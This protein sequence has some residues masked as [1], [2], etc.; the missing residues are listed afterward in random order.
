MATVVST[1]TVNAAFFREIKEEDAHVRHLRDAVREACAHPVP[2]R[3]FCWRLAGLLGQF[4]ERL[5]IRFLLEETFGYFDDPA[6]V[7][8]GF[9]ALAEDLA[10]QHEG[11][12]ARVSRLVTWTYQNL[13]LAD[14][15]S[16]CREVVPA[17]LAFCETLDEHESREDALILRAFNEDIGVCD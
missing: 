5:A 6:A 2:S 17:C 3:Q 4:R 14:Y 9:C 13:R 15:E 7:A 8:P 11:L 1:K 12:S 16:V 10:S